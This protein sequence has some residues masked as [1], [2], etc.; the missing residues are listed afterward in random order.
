M[1]EPQWAGAA[2]SVGLGGQ[3]TSLHQE[4]KPHMLRRVI[5]EVEKSLPPK[6]ERV[7]R[8]GMS[9]LQKQYYKWI[10]ERNFQDLNK[11]AKGNQVSCC[12]RAGGLG[13]CA[14]GRAR[15]P[16]NVT[17]P[18]HSRSKAS[19]TPHH[20]ALQSISCPHHL[21]LLWPPPLV[22]PMVRGELQGGEPLVRGVMLL[23]RVRGCL[24]GRCRS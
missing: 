10:L 3:I 18:A 17:L 24:R 22:A 5:K 1:R 12:R 21:L 16:K 14:Q 23:P 8:V 13:P 7:L 15:A 4:L 2:F 19:P 20:L 11:N 6:I 9:P